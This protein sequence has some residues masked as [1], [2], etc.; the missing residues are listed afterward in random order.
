MKKLFKKLTCITVLL[1]TLTLTACL[2][3][4]FLT[5]EIKSYGSTKI[6]NTYTFTAN[7][8]VETWEISIRGTNAKFYINDELYEEKD[9]STSSSI[10]MKLENLSFK[11]G[12]VCVLLV[13]GDTMYYP[14]ATYGIKINGETIN[15]N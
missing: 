9:R 5:L 1:V 8:E 6:Q 10:S 4:S 14:P 7:K 12:D 15:F 13:T 11:K 3:G 2:D